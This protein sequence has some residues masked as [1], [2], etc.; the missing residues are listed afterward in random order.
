MGNDRSKYPKSNNSEVL[1]NKLNKLKAAGDKEAICSLF[2]LN[3]SAEFNL[4]WPDIHFAAFAGNQDIIQYLISHSVDI[5]LQEQDENMTPIHIAV[6]VGNKSAVDVLLEKEVNLSIKD[7][8]GNTPLHIAMLQ[9]N[10]DIIILLYNKNANLFVK[11]NAGQTPWD[12]ANELIRLAISSYLTSHTDKMNTEIFAAAKNNVFSAVKLFTESGANITVKSPEDNLTLLHIAAKNGNHEIL[13]YLILK[14][15]DVK[16]LDPNGLTILD[17]AILKAYAPSNDKFENV[18]IGGKAGLLQYLRERI[19]EGVSP[20]LENVKLL[21]SAGANMDDSISTLHNNLSKVKNEAILNLSIVAKD[22]SALKRSLSELLN[23]QQG[24]STEEK[25]TNL[26]TVI[27]IPDYKGNTLLFYAIQK[28]SFEMVEALINSGAKIN[29]D[30]KEHN[31]LIAYA[32]QNSSYEVVELM[33]NRGVILDQKINGD[34]LLHFS[35]LR[36]DLSGGYERTKERSIARILVEK[37]VQN[38]N[39]E[40][41]N[42]KIN[43]GHD[44]GEIT[45][46]MYAVDKNDTPLA[47]KLIDKLDKDEINETNGGNTCTALS[48]AKRRENAEIEKHLRDKG[49]CEM[50]EKEADTFFGSVKNRVVRPVVNTI[51]NKNVGYMAGVL[52][53]ALAPVCPIATVILGSISFGSLMLRGEATKQDCSDY[54]NSNLAPKLGNNIGD[55]VKDSLAGLAGICNSS[56]Q[57]SSNQDNAKAGQASADINS[58]G[59]S[60]TSESKDNGSKRESPK[61]NSK[62]SN[63]SCTKLTKRSKCCYSRSLWRKY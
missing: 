28:N 32:I 17:Y 44:Y 25:K 59:I 7:R 48:Y 4:N 11:N 42:L 21:L 18:V 60:N 43:M 63:V 55:L 6:K 1:L 34:T 19:S 40:T 10:L 30:H 27:N 36:K 47:I 12:L 33:I 39:A 58:S 5:N 37:R 24:N 54:V 15:S 51:A 53:V 13:E 14:G 26:E 57:N 20:N 3:E 8:N 29:Q 52:A 62:T 31:S 41:R 38:L 45:Q 46:L 2:D 56:G 23:A 16:E 22:V 9:K 50:A 35:V 61:R 49:A